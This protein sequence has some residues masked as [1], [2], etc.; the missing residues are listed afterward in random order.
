MTLGGILAAVIGLA[1]LVV[2]PAFIGFFGISTY[3]ATIARLASLG[4]LVVFVLLALSLLY[5]F[6]PSRRAASWHWVTPGSVVATVLWLLVSALFSFYVE[7][8]ASYDA[9]YGPLGAVVGVMMWFYVSALAV[10]VGA[11]LNA[12]LELQTVHDSTSGEAKPIGARGAYVA[13]HV[14]Q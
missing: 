12:E 4:A 13:D 8:L 11:E 2:L 5:R 7:H 10:L 14:A 6:G 9:T 1:A 3:G